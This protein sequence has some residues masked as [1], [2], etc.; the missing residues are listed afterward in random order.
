[1]RTLRL[2]AAPGR[3]LV[4]FDDTGRVVTHRRITDEG[5]RDYNIGQ[6][7]ADAAVVPESVY[8]LQALAH[9]DAVIVPESVPAS[10]R[11]KGKE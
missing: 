5:L 10:Q 6:V 7:I 11:A 8:Y 3:K 9:G 4:V 2:K 1:M